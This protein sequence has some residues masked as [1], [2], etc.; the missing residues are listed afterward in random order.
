LMQLKLM[1]QQEFP[2]DPEKAYANVFW[3][4]LFK[5]PQESS[6][7]IRWE[8]L[9]MILKCSKRFTWAQH[10]AFCHFLKNHCLRYHKML[11]KQKHLNPLWPEVSFMCT[12]FQAP[13]SD[14]LT[15]RNQSVFP[16][17]KWFFDMLISLYVWFVV[18]LTVLSCGMN[19]E[20]V[21]NL[22]S[23]CSIL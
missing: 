15:T 11:K 20:V 13:N 17:C 6:Q 21:E 3:R 7:W 8:A 2:V 1:P 4:V 18:Y 10:F 23:I 12:R 14:Q 16:R 9:F 5:A 22:H 19:K